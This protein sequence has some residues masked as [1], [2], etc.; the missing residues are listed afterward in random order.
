MNQTLTEWTVSSYEKPEGDSFFRVTRSFDINKPGTDWSE[1]T[2]GV[3]GGSLITGQLTVGDAIEIRPGIV[4]KNK[5]GRHICQPIKTTVQSLKTENTLMEAITPGGLIGIGTDIDPFYIKGDKMNGQSIGL[6]GKMPPIYSELKMVYCP[7]TD[8]DG[9]WSPKNG[10]TVY[11]QL[12]NHSTESRL[13]KMYS[14]DD[15]QVLT[16]Y[17]MKP[18]CLDIEKQNKILISRK[19]DSILKIVGYGLLKSEQTALIIS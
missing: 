4:S 6:H 3:L 9:T 11:L 7:V 14:T 15:K 5:E 8:F 12:G 17:L 19:D 18:V 1:V 16:F 2:G 10:D 13:M